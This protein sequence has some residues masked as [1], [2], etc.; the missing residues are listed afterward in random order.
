MKVID[1]FEGEYD[2]KVCFLVVAK[3][4]NVP[5]ILCSLIF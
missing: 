1:I 2:E 3:I 5:A 4:T